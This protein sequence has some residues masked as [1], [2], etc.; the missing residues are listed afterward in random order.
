VLFVVSRERPDRYESLVRAFGGDMDVKVI[1]D[2]RRL[3]RRRQNATPITDRRRWERRSEWRA[4]TLRSRGW[5]R[6]DC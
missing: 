4:W 3:D 2:R 6:I 5:I 1:F